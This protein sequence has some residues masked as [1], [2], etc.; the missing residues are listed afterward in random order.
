MKSFNLQ[1]IS[2]TYNWNYG[3]VK[4]LKQNE[5]GYYNNSLSDIINAALSLVF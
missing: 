5:S 3:N 1:N 2:N 4:G